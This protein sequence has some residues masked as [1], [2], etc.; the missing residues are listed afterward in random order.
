MASNP[1]KS[2]NDTLSELAGFQ[3]ITLM[4]YQISSKIRVAGCGLLLVIFILL[5]GFYFGGGAYTETLPRPFDSQ[6][7][8]SANS[9]KDIRC[10]MLAD[11]RMR[12]GIEGKT[13]EELIELLGPDENY[14]TNPDLG[15]WLLCPSFMDIWVLEVRWKNGVAEE[16]WVRDT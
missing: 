6:I 10:A 2:R 11:L 4:S 13:R 12:I 8:R 7:W 5:P 1:A 16:A 15:L 9:W 3:Y 14:Q